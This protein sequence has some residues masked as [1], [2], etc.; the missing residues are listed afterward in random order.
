MLSKN[1]IV[2]AIEKNY[3]VG[4]IKDDK[5]GYTTTVVLKDEDIFFEN[6]AIYINPKIKPGFLK[7]ISNSIL[8]K[9][10]DD[11]D[12]GGVKVLTRFPYRKFLNHYPGLINGI[13]RNC[14]DMDLDSYVW[15]DYFNIYGYYVSTNLPKNGNDFGLDDVKVNIE[16][17]AKISE[18]TKKYLDS[19]IT[20][21]SENF[22]SI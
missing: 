1:E 6:I 5:D 11:F 17:V 16:K 3:K 7:T 4:Q 20:N 2:G 19:F 9:K 21:Q 8:F 18:K 13:Q 12:V 22:L 15:E 14:E 10:T